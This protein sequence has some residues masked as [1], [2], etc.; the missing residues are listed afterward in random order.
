MAIGTGT[1]KLSDIKNEFGSST[2]PNNLRAFLKCG[3][4]ITT[5]TYDTPGNGSITAPAGATRVRIKIWGAGGG[6][7]ASAIPAAGGGGGGGGSGA[8]VEKVLPVTGGATQYFYTV[9]SGGAGGLSTA[10]TDGGDSSVQDIPYG[11]NMLLTSGGGKGGQ[12]GIFSNGLRGAGGITSNGGDINVN[13]D[14][15]GQ[16]A[17]GG[18]APDGGAGA[19]ENVGL[20][21]AGTAPGGG[22]G[23]GRVVSG[24]SNNGTAGADGRVQ[25]IWY[26]AA[27]PEHENNVNIP[28]SGTL[29]FSNFRSIGDNVVDKDFE[30]DTYS[31]AYKFIRSGTEIDSEG[32]GVVIRTPLFESA[33]GIGTFSALNALGLNV[34]ATANTMP[35]T[36]GNINEIGQT[37]DASNEKS[38][39]NSIFDF[40]NDSYDTLPDSCTLILNGDKRAT[41][42]DLRWINVSV[43]VNNS[44]ITLNR[45][46]STVPNGSYD[47]I[48]N[49]TYWTW[50]GLFG[51]PN[52]TGSTYN[53]KVRVSII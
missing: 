51:F 29:K 42:W 31:G 16:L 21:A 32:D 18:T 38:V 48:R 37:I 39:V 9:G 1:V 13:G 2:G 26:A 30:S 4:T 11:G 28:L 17:I 53:F 44:T 24:V 5:N 7:G 20:G 33:S 52:A 14:G 23:G 12:R 3:G 43:T 47:A 15:E 25:F 50:F 49:L 27:V 6:G 22:G 34:L 41:V 8:Y 45:I 10:G 40:G 19:P 35:S 36:I 46:N